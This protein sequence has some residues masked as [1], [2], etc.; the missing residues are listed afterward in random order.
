M[1]RAL[2]TSFDRL[3][4][5]ITG[6]YFLSPEVSELLRYP[7]QRALRTPV[8]YDAVARLITPVEERGASSREPEG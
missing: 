7:G 8:D 3:T 2:G 5:L 6:A 4:F 1:L